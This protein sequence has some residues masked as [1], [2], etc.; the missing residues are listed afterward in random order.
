[1][2]FLR[3]HCA[4]AHKQYPIQRLVALYFVNMIVHTTLPEG[5]SLRHPALAMSLDT[6]WDVVAKVIFSK[7]LTEAHISVFSSDLRTVRQ[8]NELKKL[9]SVLWVSASDVIMISTQRE[10]GRS[11]TMLSPSFMNLVGATVPTELA[12]THEQISMSLVVELEAHDSS[13][14]KLKARAAY[15]V[16]T[17]F[18]GDIYN[19]Q[20]DQT[21]LA[22]ENLNG[23]VVDQV[24]GRRLWSSCW[25]AFIF[26]TD[27][28]A[29]GTVY[30]QQSL[31][32]QVA[33]PSRATV[34][35]PTSCRTCR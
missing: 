19:D 15:Y 35:Q 17:S 25:L 33:R 24:S 23:H 29:I 10:D 6:T 22:V 16:D 28:L 21:V 12:E 32:E 20:I 30:H 31:Y 27:C 8:L 5:H 4:S 14:R 1:M 13:S 2:Y 3:G 34:S 18:V 11:T 7:F 26:L 9:M